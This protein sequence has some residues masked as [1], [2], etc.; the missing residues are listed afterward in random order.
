MQNFTPFQNF[1]D[2][3]LQNDPFFSWFRAFHWSGGGGGGS[4]GA[5]RVGVGLGGGG[6]DGGGGKS[7]KLRPSAG[8]FSWYDYLYLFYHPTLILV[9]Y[10]WEN[11]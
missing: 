4:G 9:G 3:C 1:S 7:L 10:G 8:I 6:C 5:V 11:K 2:P